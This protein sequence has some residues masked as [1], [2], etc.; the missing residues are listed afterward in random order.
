MNQENISIYDLIHEVLENTHDGDDL[1]P[2]HLKLIEIAANGN[3]SEKGEVALYEL[4]ASVRQGYKKPWYHGVEHFTKDHE[5]YIYYKNVRVEHYSFEDY[6]EADK[7]IKELESDC[8]QLE[9]RGKTVTWSSLSW[10]WDE[11]FKAKKE[12]DLQ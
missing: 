8:K 11:K 2:E 10:L 12:N 5:G 1:S 6:D 4:S 3:L 9:S 7:A